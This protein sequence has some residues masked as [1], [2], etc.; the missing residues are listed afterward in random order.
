MTHLQSIGTL[1]RAEIQSTS[2]RLP[3]SIHPSR[4]WNR[5]KN[6]NEPFTNCL[7]YNE[8]TYV[9]FIIPILFSFVTNVT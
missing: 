5:K 1:W 9:I 2:G 6:S 8:L 4:K 7:A 3:N